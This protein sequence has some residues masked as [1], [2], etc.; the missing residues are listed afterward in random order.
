MSLSPAL[1]DEDSFDTPTRAALTSHRELLKETAA[2]RRETLALFFGVSARIVLEAAADLCVALGHSLGQGK[3]VGFLGGTDS[4]FMRANEL[5]VLPH[6]GIFRNIGRAWSARFI[7][8]L[9]ETGYLEVHGANRPVLVLTVE[10]EEIVAAHDEMP[11]LPQDVFSD[12]VLGPSCPRTALEGRLRHFR[13]R[14]ARVLRRTCR[15]VLPDPV[16]RALAYGRPRS[17]AE[18]EALVPDRA[19]PHAAAI[20]SILWESE[21]TS[22]PVADPP[23]PPAAAEAIGDAAPGDALAENQAP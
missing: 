1:S 5:T 2:L 18:I 14:L 3:L 23:S 13:A 22:P 8:I 6:Y 9:R 11:L 7:E 21:S 16:V 4:A 12:P 17:T 10:G 19:K 15:Q 20:W